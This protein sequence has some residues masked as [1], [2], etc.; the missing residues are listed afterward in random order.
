MSKIIHNLPVKPLS[1]RDILKSVACGFGSL[2]LSGLCQQSVNASPISLGQRHPMFPA[3]AKRVIFLFMAG[4]PSHVDSYDYKPELISNHDKDYDFTGVRFGTFGK[5]SKRKL[6]KPLWGFERYGQ[7]GQY[8]SKLF[9]YTAQMVDDLCFIKSMHTEGVAHGPSTLFLHTGATNLVRPSVGSWVTYGL[10]TEN[11]NLPAFVTLQPSS[12][13][14]GPRNHSNAFLPAIY[15]GTAIGKAGRPTSEAV[16]R[17]AVNTDLTKEEQKRRFNLLQGL[18]AAYLSD[19]EKNDQLDAVVESFELAWRMQM[20]A[21]EVF[22]FSRESEAT[23]RL[24]GIGEKHTD[25]F[26]KQCLM[27]RRMAESGVRYIQVNYADESTN[28]RWDQHSNMPKHMDHAMATD[29]PIAGLLA[30][31]KNRGLLDETL[32]WWG[33]EFGRTPFS[34]NGDGRDHNPRGF[35]TWLA[36]AGVKPGISYGETDELGD[37]AVENKVHMHDLHATILHILGLNHEKLTYRYAG[38]DFRLTDVHGA[39]VRSILS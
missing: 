35:T 21:P 13:K 15:Q 22:D 5:K 10:G 32:V 37:T 17:N 20:N 6:M 2:A 19:S 28:P 3:R 16:L 27:A 8:V 39:I 4:G 29:K 14:G 24:Y 18:N 34:Q 12:S 7:C 36:G 26:G 9:P 1:R 23:K 38:R 25:D 30:D 11:Q 31:L 33:G